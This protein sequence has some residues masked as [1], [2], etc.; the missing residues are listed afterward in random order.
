LSTPTKVFVV[1]LFVFSIAF[2]SSV[3]VHIGAEDH[4]KALAN[5][6]RARAHAADAHVRNW[7]AITA[8]QMEACQDRLAEQARAY[9]ELQGRFEQ[10]QR[11][12]TEVKSELQAANVRNDNLQTSIAKLTSQVDAL[13]KER[14]VLRDQRNELES[15][16]VKLEKR[17]IELN[18][19]VRELSTK[20]T[21]LTHQVRQLQQKAYAQAEEIQRLQARLSRPREGEIAVVGPELETA[22][23]AEP[24][25]VA[26]IEGRVTEVDGRHASI[27]VGSADGVEK[28]MVFIIHRGAQYLGDLTITLV[29]PERSAGVLSELQGEIQEGDRAVPAA[30]LA[31]EAQP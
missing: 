8:A 21:S 13:Q 28:G 12:L 6:Y 17:N 11:A 5:D 4:W 3:I 29:E 30:Q 10:V 23:A 20:V 2:T 18:D 19:R 27:S 14:T 24:P 22:R 15:E 31:G 7:T 1:L 9:E 26:R 16:N 25:K